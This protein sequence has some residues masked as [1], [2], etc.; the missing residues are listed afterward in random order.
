M[1]SPEEEATQAFHALYE[2]LDDLLQ[3]RGTK[4]MGELW[5]HADY[6][7]SSHPFGDWAPWLGRG[8]GD[9]GR[10]SRGMGRCY[11]GHAGRT[12][13]I[14]D[15]HGLRV[16]LRGDTAYGTSVYRSK[17]YMSDGELDLKVNC[18]DVVHRIGRRVEGRAPPRRSGPRVLARAHRAD[19]AA[20]AFLAAN[21]RDHELCQRAARTS[22]QAGTVSND[23][24]RPQLTNAAESSLAT[25]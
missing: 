3:G 7:T 14:G 13:R 1:A 11:G 15:I 17:L 22:D 16:A 2:A 23:R 21:A 18:T 8:V 6:V 4:K 19:G 24:I 5:H 20:R 25:P 9:L 10:G 12:D